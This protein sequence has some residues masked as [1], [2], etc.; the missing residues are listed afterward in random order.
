MLIMVQ[1]ENSSYG[2]GRRK[3][4]V[5]RVFLKAGKG[6]IIINGKPIETYMGRETDRMIMMQP[7]EAI[8]K[9]GEFDIKATVKGGGTTGQAG[10][11]RLGIA[12]ALVAYDTIH[13]SKEVSLAVESDDDEREEGES[14]T[15]PKTFRHILK[16]QG[17]LTRD[18][19]C[20]E[21]KKFGLRKARK[22]EQY[23]K[24]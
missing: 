3:S 13:P 20:V 9:V 16:A 4:S 22:K 2:T 24:R 14:G 19:R 8:S 1:V 15:G 5:A 21:R 17:Y 6:T 11:L 12:R 23:S 7:L 18:S 10:A